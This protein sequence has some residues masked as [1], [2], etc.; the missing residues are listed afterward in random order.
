MISKTAFEGMDEPASLILSGSETHF[1]SLLQNEINQSFSYSVLVK[2]QISGD[3]LFASNSL[4]YKHPMKAHITFVEHFNSS[5]PNLYPDTYDYNIMVPS[6]A[7]SK[8]E[9]KG[10]GFRFDYG[11]YLIDVLSVLHEQQVA[12]ETTNPSSPGVIRPIGT[13]NYV[14]VI[15]PMFV[16]W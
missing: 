13:D 12:L 3:S 9:V 1:I 15:M 10:Y 2:N 6:G 11:K 14:H 7:N 5:H 8:D 4:S 16:Q